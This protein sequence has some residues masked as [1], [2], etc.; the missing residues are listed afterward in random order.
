MLKA[1]KDT[2]LHCSFPCTSM[3]SQEPQ[4]DKHWPRDSS[5]FWQSGKKKCKKVSCSWVIQ[6]R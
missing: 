1:E 4:L 5:E 6:A 3:T 2:F